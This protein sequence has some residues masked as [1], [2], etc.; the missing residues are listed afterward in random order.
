[1]LVT[2]LG[3]TAKSYLRA[4]FLSNFSSTLIKINLKNDR[5]IYR[6]SANRVKYLLVTFE[7]YCDA[8]R[9]KCGRK[10]RPKL[11]PFYGGGPDVV[12]ILCSSA[13]YTT[14]RF[15]FGI[16][17]L[18]VYVFFCPFSILITLLG[19]RE[20]VFVLIVHLFVSYA[21]VNLCHFC[22]FLL[23]SRAGC[24]FCLWLFLD[25]SIYL[26]SDLA[27]FLFQVQLDNRRR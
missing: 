22:L 13:L 11:Q 15:M 14:R 12:L 1:M 3:W 2:F 23:V 16:V 5:Q 7:I 10:T 24:G 20:L 26:F 27:A 21:H 19:K 8:S 6:Q 17:L 18:F 25:F 4:R 9:T